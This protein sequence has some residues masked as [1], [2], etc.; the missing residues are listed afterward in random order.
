MC[1]GEFHKTSTKRLVLGRVVPTMKR[2]TCKTCANG[3]SVPTLCRLAIPRGRAQQKQET[4]KLERLRDARINAADGVARI[5]HQQHLQEARAGR[6]VERE[7][8][9]LLATCATEEDINTL[10]TGPSP[11]SEQD[12]P[13][14][15]LKQQLN[16]MRVVKNY[17]VPKVSALKKQQC[18]QAL[19][20]VIAEVSAASA[21]AAE[22]AGTGLGADD[23]AAA[24][25]EGTPAATP[26]ATSGAS[27]TQEN[28]G[29]TVPGETP[30]STHTG[31]RGTSVR[32]QDNLQQRRT[33]PA[34]FA[35]LTVAK[36][37]RSQAEISTDGSKRARL[38]QHASQRYRA[39]QNN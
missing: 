32:V 7:N 20:T 39:S 25:Q 17:N 1:I 11:F 28:Q 10:L 14:K 15:R 22:A 5:A 33:G 8:L 9:A 4:K 12:Q 16:H 34:V 35:P 19:R 38:L 27:T 23:A 30:A 18:I 13:L 37:G 26:G 2:R 36:R 31:D 6:Q 3:M 24:D 21:A 29:D